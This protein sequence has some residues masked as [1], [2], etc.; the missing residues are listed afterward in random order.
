MGDNYNNFFKK[1]TNY[2]GNSFEYYE[3]TH[4]KNGV[5]RPLPSGFVVDNTKQLKKGLLP[6]INNSS[7]LQN[8]NGSF[9]NSSLSYSNGLVGAM[10]LPN[11]TEAIMPR[12][13]QNVVVYE[14]KSPEDVQYLIDFLK[15]KEP[16]IVDLNKQDVSVAQRILDQLSGA[17]Y[18]LNGNILKINASSN[19]F[20]LSPEGVMISTPIRNINE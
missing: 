7:F 9:G 18:A 19:I 16:A 4:D 14:P 17:I 11:E 2:S 10:P 20:F 8:N 15:R 3:D 13:Y 1:N 5:Y 6:S 12:N